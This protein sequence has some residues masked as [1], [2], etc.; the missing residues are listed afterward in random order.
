MDLRGRVAFIQTLLDPRC[1]QSV[2]VTDHRDPP[3]DD[4]DLKAVGSSC[5][6]RQV[7]RPDDE[8]N[9]HHICRTGFSV[10]MTPVCLHGLSVSWM[11][12]AVT[13][14]SS[15]GG[16]GAGVKGVLA[17]EY[18]P[19]HRLA[20]V[21]L[22]SDSEAAEV[23]Q[24]AFEV[25]TPRLDS[26]DDV[27][28]GLRS[29]VVSGVRRRLA[30]RAAWQPKREVAAERPSPR[31]GFGQS[32]FE[33][34]ADLVGELPEREHLAVVLRYYAGW[35]TSDIGEALECPADVVA[36]VLADC[37]L[38]LGGQLGMSEFDQLEQTLS[39]KLDREAA[40]AHPPSD[41]W[42]RFTATR[43]REPLGAV[44]P[45]DGG[46]LRHSA[47]RSYGFFDAQADGPIPPPAEDREPD[48]ARKRRWRW[49]VLSAAA[50]A[51]A[52]V[53]VV[54]V[55]A[56]GTDADANPVFE[57]RGADGNDD[58][59][60]AFAAVYAAYDA[61]NSGDGLAWAVAR[62]APQT[63]V[64]ADELRFANSLMA[65][66]A[67][68]SVVHCDYIGFD[69]HDV[70]G[71]P[72]YSPVE[73]HRFDCVANRSDAFTTASHIELEQEFRWLVDRTGRVVDCRSDIPDGQAL[74][75]FAS[76]FMNWIEREHPE[77]INRREHGWYSYPSA[78]DMPAALELLDDFVDGAT[79]D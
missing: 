66:G 55:A 28:A 74:E 70:I 32:G 24:D 69:M 61:F 53:V 67:R 76:N 5:H 58:A 50:A 44:E 38:G 56:S 78:E 18:E 6:S 52:V 31:G 4:A 22:G 54:R 45:L 19:M 21:L 34:L 9:P 25:I 75:R 48:T 15:A 36:S 79:F 63:A 62:A 1:R 33:H 17:D 11:M 73:A 40:R 72:G 2:D 13:R 71:H 46:Q 30:Y 14:S 64:E 60:A 51:V 68:F 12:A 42:E 77:A 37:L 27:G 16:R 29:E 47:A 8:P 39:M 57:L 10:A 65:A 43:D 49:A 20:F 41:A 59:V 7:S 26:I 3:I 35:A 23:V